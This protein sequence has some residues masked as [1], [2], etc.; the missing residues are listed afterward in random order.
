[1]F[2]VWMSVGLLFA[3]AGF[4]GVFL[5][6]LPGGILSVAGMLL[7]E[8]MTEVDFGL[9]TWIIVGVLIAAGIVSD[10]VFPLL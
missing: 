6:V 5:P 9:I 1:M 3:L 2:H 10:Y 4:A 8:F 7:V